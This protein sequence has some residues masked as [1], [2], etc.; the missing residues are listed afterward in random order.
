MAQ[1]TCVAWRVCDFHF[2]VTFC[3]LTSTFINMAFELMQ[4]PSYLFT[5]ILNEFELLTA[6][7]TDPRAQNVKTLHFDI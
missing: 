2:T 7:L 3:E 5:S 6:R 1:K 4:Y